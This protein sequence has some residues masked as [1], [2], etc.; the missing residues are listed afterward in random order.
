[1]GELVHVRGLILDEMARLVGVASQ[2]CVLCH[3]AVSEDDRDADGTGGLCGFHLEG[4]T[5]GRD[6]G[7]SPVEA[8]GVRYP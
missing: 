5:L 4:E 7:K 1:M 2:R 8:G 6:A 3:R